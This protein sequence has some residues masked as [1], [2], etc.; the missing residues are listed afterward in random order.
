[1]QGLQ[2]CNFFQN[3]PK[4]V[5]I[6]NSNW[7]KTNLLTRALQKGPYFS[8]TIFCRLFWD[9]SLILAEARRSSPK[10]AE[11]SSFCVMDLTKI[12][13]KLPLKVRFFA[14]KLHNFNFIASQVSCDVQM[15]HPG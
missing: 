3:I 8:E 4:K 11:K 12:T 15:I 7:P 9:M 1:M 6:F 13:K 10:L 14:L 2:K 5:L